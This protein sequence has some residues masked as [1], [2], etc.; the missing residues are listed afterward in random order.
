MTALV[1]HING[2][3]VQ[4]AISSDRRVRERLAAIVGESNV[5]EGSP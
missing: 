2:T 5:R 4:R 3:T 1:L